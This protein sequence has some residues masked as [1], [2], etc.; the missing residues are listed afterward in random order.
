MTKNAQGSIHQRMAEKGYVSQAAA[1]HA[2][3]VSKP[4]IGRMIKRDE[5][6]SFKHGASV[7]VCWEELLRALGQAAD[8]LE[9]PGE[10][11]EVV[12]RYVGKS[13]AKSSERKSSKRKPKAETPAEA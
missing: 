2:L 1:A 12:S 11:S 9:I 6:D 4:T 10:A 13:P 7:Y 3:A 5:L 8:V